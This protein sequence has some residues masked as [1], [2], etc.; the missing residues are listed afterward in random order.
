M[1][2]IAMDPFPITSYEMT[3]YHLVLFKVYLFVNP[4][5]FIHYRKHLL[6][7]SWVSPP[8]TFITL[9][10]SKKWHITTSNFFKIN[11]ITGSITFLYH[12]YHF[13]EP[14]PNHFAQNGTLQ[15]QVCSK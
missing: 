8:S 12:E 3:Q 9:P 4:D 10:L 15:A 11:T 5:K 1:S 7:I 2:L 14:L 13:L 6:L